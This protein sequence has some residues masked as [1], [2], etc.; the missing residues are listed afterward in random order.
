VALATDRRGA[1]IGQRLPEV[2]IHRVAA[3]PLAG[4]RLWP[5]LK[6]MGVMGL[7]VI[8]ARWLLSR[9]RPAV[10]IGFGGYPTVPTVL[11]AAQGGVPIVLHEQNAVMGRA[12]RSLAPRAGRLALTF[13][14]TREVR[15]ADR[16]RV[17]VTGNPVRPAVRAL[18]TRDFAPPTPPEPFR[19]LVVGGS[20][21]ARVL[22]DIVP[23]AFES[24]PPGL[25][26]GIAVTQQAR[27]EDVERV[28]QAYAALAVPAEVAPFFDDLPRRLGQAHLAICRAGAST[29]AELGVAGVPAILVPL[30]IA[31][32]DHQTVN[33]RLLEAAGAAWVMPQPDFQPPALARRLFNLIR[34]GEALVVASAK[35]RAASHPDAAERLADL[36]AAALPAPRET[37]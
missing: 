22:A 8:Q 18:A 29:V 11:A 32:D 26:A 25:R 6:A 24:L 19:L 5:R 1:A 21:G 35:A 12:N 31:A 28:R 27:A 3:A 16:A 17:T 34:D 4:A 33:A 2:A 36:V 37:A 15:D 23:A 30:P 7:G 10:V 14:E 13:A 9:I 20:Q